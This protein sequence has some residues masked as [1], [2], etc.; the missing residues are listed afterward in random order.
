MTMAVLTFEPLISPALWLTLA[1]LAAAMMIVYAARRPASIR[2]G[3]WG[4]VIA[5]MAGGIL[6]TL[7]ILLNPTWTSEIAPPA[8]KPLLTM[9]IDTSASMATTDADDGRS[10]YEVAR[11]TAEATARDLRRFFEVRLRTFDSLISPAETQELAGRSPD[12]QTTDLASSITASLEQDQPQGQAVLLLSDGIHNAGGG[13]DKVRVAAQLAKAMSA[14]IYTKTIG[15]QSSVYDLRVE[16]SSPQQLAYIGQRVPIRAVIRHIGLPGASV[17]ASLMYEGRT[18]DRRET[19]LMP[20]GSTEVRFHISQDRQGLYRYE[21]RVEPLPG[22]VVQANNLTSCVLQVVDEPIRVFMIEGKPYWDGK[23][24]V[25]TLASDPAM[26][27]D[28]V[29]RLADG[30]LL[31]RTLTRATST[32]RPENPT[33]GGDSPNGVVAAGSQP[34]GSRTE[35]WT[36]LTSIPDVLADPEKM[37]FYQVIVLGRDTEQFLNETSIANLRNWVSR[38]GG[39]LLCYRGTPVAQVDERLGRLLPVRWSPT[40]ETRF[41]VQ[42]TEQGR[43]L[44][45]LPAVD[46]AAEEDSLP[47]LPTLAMAAKPDK[48]K[49]MAVVLAATAAEGGEDTNPVLTYQPYGIGRVVV[50]EGS[51]M[52]RWAFLPPEHQSH[53]EVYGALW[54]SLLRWLVSNE[55][56]RPGQESTLQA[57]KITFSTVEPATAT[58]LIREE[59]ARHRIPSVELTGSALERAEAFSPVAAGDDPGVFR[60]DFGRLPEGRY[61]AGIVGKKKEAKSDSG[62]IAFDVR[63]FAE[64]R[65]NLKARPDLM[66]RIAAESGGVSIEADAASEITRSFRAYMAQSRPARITRMTAWDRWWVFVCVMLTWGGA[67]GLRRSGGLI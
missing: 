40:R 5:L 32:S 55:H 11:F 67:W 14:P 41:H 23:F 19:R 3:R 65:L 7:L 59:A 51:G 29:V 48:P 16:M 35:N 63:N 27:I 22:E 1:I 62:R 4:A 54:Q 60:V 61:E 56:L 39:S 21:V 12:G 26:A 52:W 15:G 8:G 43:D 38:E 53:D 24:L 50:V 31:R 13:V 64:E 66:A 10:R 30:R 45:W 34:A 57:D 2:R 44:R 49:P 9:L 25:R 18:I 37:K 47:Q 28:S 6:L 58:L 17:A 33:G 36:I 42:L 20:E 46:G